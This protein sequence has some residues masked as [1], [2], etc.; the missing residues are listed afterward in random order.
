M[1]ENVNKFFGS[2]RKWVLREKIWLT[3]IDDSCS[4]ITSRIK[5]VFSCI[6]VRTL[7]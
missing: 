4:N 6:S 3:I 1:N 2:T 7:R 5:E